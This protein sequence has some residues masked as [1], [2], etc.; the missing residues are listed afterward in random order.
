[1]NDL[2]NLHSQIANT[3]ITNTH[4]P[5]FLTAP[6]KVEHIYT[7]YHIKHIFQ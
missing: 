7:Y 2:E 6:G 3:L 5:L 1:M 4:F